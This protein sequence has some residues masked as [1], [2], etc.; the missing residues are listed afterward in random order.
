MGGTGAGALRQQQLPRPGQ[1]GLS[2][3]PKKDMQKLIKV[4]TWGQGKGAGWEEVGEGHFSI[5]SSY[6][7]LIFEQCDC[8]AKY[9]LFKNILFLSFK[10]PGF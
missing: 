10:R 7:F 3:K 1:R 4:V 9:H 8:I 2:R 5:Y 6:M